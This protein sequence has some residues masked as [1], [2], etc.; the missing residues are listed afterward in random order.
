MNCLHCF[1][2]KFDRIEY[3]ISSAPVSA[4]PG[5]WRNLYPSSGMYSFFHQ[6]LSKYEDLGGNFIYENDYSPFRP[7]SANGLYL[8]EK[9]SGRVD[10]NHR[11]P[12]PE[13]GAR[14]LLKREETRGFLKL[15]IEPFAR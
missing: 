14:V 12:G 10:L 5:G 13:S 1:F 7:Y 9:K 6:A 8:I 15:S 3:G 4:K 11:P 2:P